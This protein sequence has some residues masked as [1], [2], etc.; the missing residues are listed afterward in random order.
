MYRS[1]SEISADI[2]Q[3]NKDIDAAGD[4]KDAVDLIQRDI[5]NNSKEIVYNIE[6]KLY[7]DADVGTMVIG[8]TTLSFVEAVSDMG[9]AVTENFN[10]VI[11]TINDILTKIE[12]YINGRK[13]D[14]YNFIE[15]YNEEVARIAAEEAS[16]C[17]DNGTDWRFISGGM[18]D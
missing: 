2:E 5:V 14:C 4:L 15:E 8:G 17:D 16:H 3:C 11:T 9:V 18:G 12:S 13:D 6:N 10:L 7:S 1:L